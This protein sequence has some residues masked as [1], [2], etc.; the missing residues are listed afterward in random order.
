MLKHFS[1][2][3]HSNLRMNKRLGFFVIAGLSMII[4]FIA[5]ISTKELAKAELGMDKT[6]SERSELPLLHVV[7]TVWRDI[8]KNY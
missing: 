3:A 6:V 4:S 7:S 8:T 2:K 1:K 5:L